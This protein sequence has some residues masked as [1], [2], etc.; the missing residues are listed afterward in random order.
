MTKKL[1][2]DENLGN[3]DNT[4]KTTHTNN[5]GFIPKAC[6]TL[7]HSEQLK[8]CR[9]LAVLSAKGLIRCQHQNIPKQ[10]KNYSTAKTGDI[11]KIIPKRVI[12]PI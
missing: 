4:V 8:L 2:I 10:L 3:Y 6:Q 9:V 1:K 5:T 11:R 12:K 7:L